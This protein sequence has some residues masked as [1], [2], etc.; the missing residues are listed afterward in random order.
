MGSILVRSV[1]LLLLE[2]SAF[3]FSCRHT[4]FVFPF[5]SFCKHYA[6]K[7]LLPFVSTFHQVA[8]ISAIQFLAEFAQNER[9]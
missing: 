7:Q 5:L 2:F 4:S 1:T 9:C 3:T 6:V 8:N